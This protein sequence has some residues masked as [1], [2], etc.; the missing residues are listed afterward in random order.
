M[1]DIGAPELLLILGVVVIIFGPSKLAGLGG[2]L[3]Q[4]IRE[5][6]RALVGA[7][8]TPRSNT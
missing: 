6:R 5:F 1:L 2:A 4:S 7:D 8:E 3:G